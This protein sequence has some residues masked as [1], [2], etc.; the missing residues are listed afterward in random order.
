MMQK[1]RTLHLLVGLVSLWVLGCNNGEGGRKTQPTDGANADLEPHFCGKPVLEDIESEKATSIGIFELQNDSA[2]LWVTFSCGGGL[3]LESLALF[4]GEAKDCPHLPSGAIDPSRFPIQANDLHQDKPWSARIPLEQL[5]PCPFIAAKMVLKGQNGAFEG[6]LKTKGGKSAL[7]GYLYCIQDCG[8]GA[9]HCDLSD[10]LQW[11]R[12]VPQAEWNSANG[13]LAA[14]LKDAWDDLY[15]NG[16][17]LG[18]NQ[19]LQLDDAEAV[20]D[21]LPMQGKPASLTNPAPAAKSLDNLLAGE[22]LTLDLA[23]ALDQ[24]FPDF[25]PSPLPLRSFQVNKGA[26][27]GWSLQEIHDEGNNVLGAC[28]SNYT[29]AQIAE[30]LQAINASFAQGRQGSDYLRCPVD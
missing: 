5:P 23:M 27:E 25:G 20:L 4:A 2:F 21:L 24:Q 28:T 30:V 10:T 26:F 12:T 22:L 17:H 8:A 29:A 19:Q 3:T 13:A 15:P 9:L 1:L 6:I 14:Q 16:I 11:P 18:C 7:E